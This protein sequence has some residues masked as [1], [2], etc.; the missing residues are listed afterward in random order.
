[1]NQIIR[2]FLHQGKIC[3][4]YLGKCIAFL[5]PKNKKLIL[6]SSWFA[7]KY[8]DSPMYVY[9]YMLQNVSD[10]QVY[11]YTNN[12]DLYKSLRDENKP[13]IYGKSLKG[14]WT[15][16]RAAMLVSTVEY[17]DYNY[18]F[19]NKCILLDLDHGFPI[20]QSGYEIPT[21]S[22]KQIQYDQILRKGVTLYKTASST[23]I[24][25]I[26]TRCYKIDG[27]NV[28]FCNKARTDAL[29]DEALR[30][31][32]NKIVESFGKN[33]K[34]ITYAPT[35]RNAGK[36]TID[37]TQI[38]DLERIEA[39]CKKH[40]AVFLIKK[41]FYHS[42]ESS[43]LKQY[44]CIF[45]ITNC[46]IETQTLLYQSDVLITDYSAIYIDYLLLDRPIMFYAF[47]YA[48]YQENERDLYLKLEDNNAGYKSF[49][50]EGFYKQLELVCND[51]TDKKHLEGRK[52]IRQK[53]F[54]DDVSIGDSRKQ[55]AG[56]ICEM[57]AG[58]YKTKW[59]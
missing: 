58:R 10:Y 22:K 25:D 17:F 55:I 46:D 35:H 44:E 38:F 56:M 57:V 2:S 52:L 18:Y 27:K 19:I 13:V 23:W 5:I 30:A 29:F 47:D 3:F 14:L 31:G 33:K 16:L 20:K 59:Q 43:D 42:K 48:N 12:L 11:W 54:D 7:K 40:K 50:F 21:M 26:I 51:W 34:I 9:E 28:A 49:D 36:D 8:A 45:D 1:M 24:K 41:H 4:T 37:V 15:Q 6:F 53:Y 39:L 32:H